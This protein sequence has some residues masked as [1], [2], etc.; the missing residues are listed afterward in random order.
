LFLALSL[1]E[2]KPFLAGS[3]SISGRQQAHIIGGEWHSRDQ[4]ERELK[5]NERNG[6]RE[7][8]GGNEE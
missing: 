7:Q 4:S 3:C 1:N 6:L 8:H 2:S 5:D